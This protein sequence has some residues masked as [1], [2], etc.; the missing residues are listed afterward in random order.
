MLEREWCQ[1]FD[2][3]QYHWE[4]S[5]RSEWDCIER[6]AGEMRGA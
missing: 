6:R 3:Q 5:M 4:T 1:H 2:W